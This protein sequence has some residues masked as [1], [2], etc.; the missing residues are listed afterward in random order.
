MTKEQIIDRHAQNLKSWV[1]TSLAKEECIGLI[2]N[3][4]NEAL[5]LNAVLYSKNYE[6]YKSWK[7]EK[8]DY[9]YYEATNLADCD[10]FMKH[11]KT[12]DEIKAEIDQE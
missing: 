9:D 12:I 3:A 11:A 5:T 10:A 8:G 2:K 7:I 6:V 4:V 1:G